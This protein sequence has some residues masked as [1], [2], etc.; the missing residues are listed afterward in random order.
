MSKQTEIEAAVLRRL[1]KHLDENKSVQNIDLMNLA[2]FCR[3]CLSKWYM[4]EAQE[5]GVAMDYDKAREFV[6]GEP[7]D[8][9]KA[10]YQPEATPEQLATFNAKSESK[11]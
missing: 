10:K 8:T 4:A 11:K 1:L 6:Y 9:W 7:Y 2:G 3:N 5:Q